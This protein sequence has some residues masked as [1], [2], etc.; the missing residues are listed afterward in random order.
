MKFWFFI[1][2]FNC[3]ALDRCLHLH[4]DQFHAFVFSV[5]NRWVWTPSHHTIQSNWIGFGSVWESPIRYLTHSAGVDLFQRSLFFFEHVENT[6]SRS[7][8]NA[9]TYVCTAKRSFEITCLLKPNLAKK[10]T[11]TKIRCKGQMTPAIYSTNGIV[12]AIRWVMGCTVPS[13]HLHT[14]NWTNY[15]DYNARNGS[16]NYPRNHNSWVNHMSD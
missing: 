6:S 15:C 12:W 16:C 7:E 14:C 10:Y 5:Q 3:P 2:W 11:C 4:H 1:S 13:G 9:K 8:A